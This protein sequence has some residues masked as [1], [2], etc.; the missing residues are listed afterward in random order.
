MLKDNPQN[1]VQ[2][3]LYRARLSSIIDLRHELVKLAG[4]VE[5]ECL[6]SDLASFYCAGQGRP[7][8]SIRLMAGLC[9][10]KDLKGLS[11]E[12]VCEV[13]RENP[14]FQYFC[15]EDYFQHRLP[16][17]P[18]QNT[19]SLTCEQSGSKSGINGGFDRFALQ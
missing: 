12:E 7:G 2:D 15:G 8:G 9:F 1:S 18:G 16:V 19:K 11:D 3:D 4:L 10:L 13:W 5:W 14:Y 6:K 17:E